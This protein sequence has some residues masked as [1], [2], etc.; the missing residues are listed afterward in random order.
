MASIL[1]LAWILGSIVS[2]TSLIILNKYIM[3]TYDFRSAT[4]L[5]AYHFFLTFGL[6][7]IM[8]RLGYVDRAENIPQSEKW[9]MGAFGVGAVVFMNYNLRLNSIGFYQLSKLSCIPFIVLYNFLF[10]KKPTPFLTLCSLAALL[11]GLA[12]FTVNDVQLNLVGFIIAAL[13]VVC[14]S[15]FQAKTGSKQKQFAVTGPTLQHATSLAQFVLA[16]ITAFCLET[17]GDRSV[18]THPFCTGETVAIVISGFIAVSVN[19]CSFGLIG[20]TNAITYQVVGHMKTILIFVFG[21]IMFPP[22]AAETPQQFIK[23][24]AG[25][26]IS[27]TGVIAYSYLEIREREVREVQGNV[28]AVP[29]DDPEPPAGEMVD[30]KF[31]EPK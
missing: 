23:K 26:I 30:L 17:Y 4:F 15:V 20:R 1:T 13:G 5:T 10:E 7:E 12:L 18:L 21:L 9:S 27:M 2:S 19:V 31:E 11:V 16:L 8:V 24:I 14:V 29:S 22:N 6:L 25:L 28:E 3:S